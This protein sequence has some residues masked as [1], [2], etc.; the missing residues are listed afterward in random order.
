LRQAGYTVWWDFDLIGGET[1]RSTILQE[2]K[3]SRAVIVLW[4]QA[5]ISSRWV[6]DEADEGLQAGKLIPLHTDD[7]RPSDVP[8]GFRALHTLRQRDQQGLLR[9]IQTVLSQPA[10][11]EQQRHAHIWRINK[12]LPRRFIYGALGLISI[13]MAFLYAPNFRLKYPMVRA[14]QIKFRV[15]SV[16]NY[17]FVFTRT[18][19]PFEVDPLGEDISSKVFGKQGVVARTP[20]ISKTVTLPANWTKIGFSYSNLNESPVY[21]KR[22]Y[23]KITGR[24]PISEEV[25]LNKWLPVI[26]PHKL[27]VHINGTED[28][29]DVAIPKIRLDPQTLEYFSLKVDGS[30]AVEKI[31]SFKILLNAHDAGGREVTIDSEREFFLT[32]SKFSLL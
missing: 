9:A 10:A 21:V 27:H 19:W 31:I 11:P 14:D 16:E 17:D 15:D 30:P 32:L 13:G 22:L 18:K 20:F 28:T 23:I 26:E 1:F 3:A 5:S 4:S 29:F 25:N 8:L 6:H 24:Y 7:I 2:L 12:T